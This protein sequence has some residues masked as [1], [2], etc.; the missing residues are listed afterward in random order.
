M[1]NKKKWTI[2]Q[3]INLDIDDYEDYFSD[4]E[5]EYEEEFSDD[6]KWEMLYDENRMWL[7]DERVNLNK[8]LE[9][10]IVVIADL[11]LWNGRR[12]GYKVIKSGNIKDCLYDDADYVEW[13]CDRWNFRCTAHHHDGTNYYLYREIRPDLS[14]TQRE[15]FLDRLYHGYIHD[16]RMIRRYTKSIRPEIANVYGWK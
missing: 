10:D 9:G 1:K 12:G 4:L 16:E 15:N 2:W 7:D 3:N 14:E 6:R 8:K 13:Y 5:T 11:G